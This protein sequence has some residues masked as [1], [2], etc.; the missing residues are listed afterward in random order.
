MLGRA[1]PARPIALDPC[2]VAQVPLAEAARLLLERAR[3][4]PG[5][6]LGMPAHRWYVLQAGNTGPAGRAFLREIWA[7]E[8][9][10]ARRVDIA[11]AC[12]FDRSD[13]TRAFLASIV[14]G[15]RATPLEV[16]HAADLLVHKG[17]AFE[18]APLLKRVA[19]ATS[20]ARVRP[21]LDCL[22]RTW[23]GREAL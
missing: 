8:P 21:A 3:S 12:A 10:P 7:T 6:V 9:D 1:V 20:D 18:V 19:L 23:Y 16:L 15:E 2:A 5:E 22:L 4:T 17:P 11:V 13:V 14:S